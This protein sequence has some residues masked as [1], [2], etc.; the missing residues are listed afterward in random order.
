MVSFPF[1]VWILVG[2]KGVLYPHL[3]ICHDNR[4]RDILQAR[5]SL[6]L[7]PTILWFLYYLLA[8]WIC[9][10]EHILYCLHNGERQCRLSSSLAIVT[11]LLGHLCWNCL[12]F[13]HYRLADSSTL[14]YLDFVNKWS[15]I[16]IFSLDVAE[17]KL[18]YE[19]W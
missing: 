12:F 19:S 8:W 15:A 16:Y 7:I 11:W 2:T 9:G 4:R 3:D 17:K 5:L 13:F 14:L 18:R 10:S 1:P 6:F